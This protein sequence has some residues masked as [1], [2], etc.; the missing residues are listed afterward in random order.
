[1]SMSAASLGLN[2]RE[3]RVKGLLGTS[4]SA[5]TNDFRACSCDSMEVAAIIA[6]CDKNGEEKQRIKLTEYSNPTRVREK[7]T[8]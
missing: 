8:F 4:V 7:E 5:F 2:K 3:G 6:A 1:M